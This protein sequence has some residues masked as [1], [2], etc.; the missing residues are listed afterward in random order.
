MHQGDST[1]YTG[2]HA[3]ERRSE[4]RKQVSI[5]FLVKIGPLFKARGTIKDMNRQGVCLKCPELFKP[6]LN[7]QVGDFINSKLKISIPSKGLT[8][9]GK[10]A[11]VNLKKGEGAIR[12]TDSS[13]QARW[14]DLN[15]KGQ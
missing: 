11:W 12:L 15:E 4:E 14:L 3:S 9:D 8:L 1:M 10:I 13:D 2:E 6:R 7:I 5:Y